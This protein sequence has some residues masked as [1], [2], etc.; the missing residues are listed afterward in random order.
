VDLGLDA[1][2]NVYAGDRSWLLLVH[3]T[4]SHWCAANS[5]TGHF[6]MSVPLY[7]GRQ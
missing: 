4:N 6:S 3:D 2:S 5:R 1:W 7:G